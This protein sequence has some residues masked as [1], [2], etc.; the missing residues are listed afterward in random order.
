MLGKKT[1]T[2]IIKNCSVLMLDTL[3][4]NCNTFKPRRKLAVFR[5]ALQ[6]R[7]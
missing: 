3:L 4:Q 2:K 1:N 5:A 7:V 6:Q